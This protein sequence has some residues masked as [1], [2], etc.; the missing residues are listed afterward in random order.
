MAIKGIQ[1]VQ[2]TEEGKYRRSRWLQGLPVQPL[3]KCG[4]DELSL[5]YLFPHAAASQSS[6][7]ELIKVSVAWLANDSFMLQ[8]VCKRIINGLKSNGVGDYT[9]D[10]RPLLK[11]IFD[12]VEVYFNFTGSSKCLKLSDPDQIGADMW[13]YQVTRRV[14]YGNIRVHLKVVLLC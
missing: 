1:T 14:L 10:S 12:G 8:Q 4:H 2:S 9:E 6:Q 7:G 5:S 13:D 3:D 11:S